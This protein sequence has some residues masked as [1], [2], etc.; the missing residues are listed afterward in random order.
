MKKSYVFIA[1]P[2]LL[3]FTFALFLFSL[4][5]TQSTVEAQRDRGRT[6]VTKTATPEGFVATP[7]PTPGVKPG[8]GG[9]TDLL[10]NYGEFD[11]YGYLGYLINKKFDVLTFYGDPEFYDV[12][13]KHAYGGFAVYP[14]Y[15]SNWMLTVDDT[16]AFDCQQ[17]E[18]MGIPTAQTL[19]W[20]HDDLSAPVAIYNEKWDTVEYSPYGDAFYGLGGGLDLVYLENPTLR[21]QLAGNPY[22]VDAHWTMEGLLA[23]LTAPS[24]TD[25]QRNLD[26]VDPIT[27]ETFISLPMPDNTNQIL[28]GDIA[29]NVWVASDD[30]VTQYNIYEGISAD[31]FAPYT[32]QEN[33]FFPPDPLL[34]WNDE[35]TNFILPIM[36][37]TGQVY[38]YDVEDIANPIILDM[39]EA[40]PAG[41]EILSARWTLDG[42]ELLIG[43]QGS[44]AWWSFENDTP[45]LVDLISITLTET[46]D[47]ELVYG[48]QPRQLEWVLDD[49][50]IVVRTESFWGMDV[51]LQIL[52]LNNS[53]PIQ[54]L[55]LDSTA[56]NFSEDQE[57]AN[58]ILRDNRVMVIDL[59][60]L[61][62]TELDDFSEA[63][64]D[65]EPVPTPNPAPDFVCDGAL[66]PHLLVGKNAQV[67]VGENGI[68][69]VYP[70]PS[71]SSGKLGI[72]PDSTIALV[73]DGPRC[74]DNGEVWYAVFELGGD[75]LQGWTTVSGNGEYWMVQTDEEP[76]PDSSTNQG[77]SSEDFSVIQTEEPVN[78]D[79][80]IIDTEEPVD[81]DTTSD[82]PLPPSQ[83]SEFADILLIYDDKSFT[84][85]NVSGQDVD[86]SELFFVG[87]VGIFFATDWENEFLA[88]PLSAFPTDSCLQIWAEGY[89]DLPTPLECGTRQNWVSGGDLDD[90][91]LDSVI[92]DVLIG[93]TYITTC[94]VFATV[95][96]VDLP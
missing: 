81:I 65:Y 75:Y 60:T 78:A 37:N 86:I 11:I 63:E 17:F 26:I 51:S 36:S 82:L 80:A 43:V 41:E 44:V 20:S 92:F 91:W 87:E 83:L 25:V 55:Q 79:N 28:T 95:C 76:L 54:I 88:Y 23:V 19:L 67:T 21:M 59:L 31:L 89:N 72:L 42:D 50:I 70:D 8:G 94:E 4:P 1:T 39:S 7:S 46:T 58:V 10:A 53:D 84:A 61:E 93:E 47:T 71:Y 30:S 29:G 14:D 62:M 64:S 12:L 22:V 85:V 34:F 57:T 73:L 77:T 96:E 38:L 2:L 32:S 24:N 90:F 69:D 33:N 48:V 74:G 45:E 13:P 40:F 27:A 16:T 49:T 5:M 68:L 9:C 6:R 35:W 18:N 56:I 15:Y 3:L 66:S 52:D